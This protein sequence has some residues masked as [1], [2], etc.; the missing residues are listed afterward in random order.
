[1]RGRAAGDQV[2]FEVSTILSSDAPEVRP[3]RLVLR[4]TKEADRVQLYL[5]GRFSSDPI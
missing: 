4:P 2:R 3:R 5:G 1:M